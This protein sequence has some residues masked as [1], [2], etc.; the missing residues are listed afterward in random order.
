MCR[1]ASNGMAENLATEKPLSPECIVATWTAWPGNLRHK[2]AL[3]EPAQYL[4]ANGATA[5]KP[6]GPPGVHSS[7]LGPCTLAGLTE[8]ACKPQLRH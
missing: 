4:A 2:A 6:A 8:A 1:V 5:Q 3:V 7:E